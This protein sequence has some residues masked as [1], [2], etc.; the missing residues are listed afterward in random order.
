MAYLV[1]VISVLLR[2]AL[3]LVFRPPKLKPYEDAANRGIEEDSSSSADD[4]LDLE[5]GNGGQK[6]VV[7]EEEFELTLDEPGEE[8]GGQSDEEELDLVFDRPGPG[9]DGG[10]AGPIEELDLLIEEE[11]D[12]VQPD[13]GAI[14]RE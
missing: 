3:V 11:S 6:T 7:E 1:G 10:V 4:Q 13:G 5:V 12:G 8:M 9:S 14:G 2:I